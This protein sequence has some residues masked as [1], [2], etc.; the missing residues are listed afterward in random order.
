MIR[1]THKK[2]NGID[3]FFVLTMHGSKVESRKRKAP[4]SAQDVLAAKAALEGR[5]WRLSTDL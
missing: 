3:L 1:R 2:L 5:R 4:F